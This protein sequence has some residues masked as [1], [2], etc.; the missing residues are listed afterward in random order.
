MQHCWQTTPNIVDC[1]MLHPFA[2]PVACCCVL[3]ELILKTKKRL[4]NG[5]G[6]K[7]QSLL[8]TKIKQMSQNKFQ[9]P[10]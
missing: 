1:Y 4:D 7:F 9:P 3:L 10:R 6:Q 2:H 8:L 5:M